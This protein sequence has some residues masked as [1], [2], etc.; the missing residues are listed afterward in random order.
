VLREHADRLVCTSVASGPLL[1]AGTLAQT[2]QGLG[3]AAETATQ[4]DA[5]LARALQLTRADGWVLVAGSF[6]LAGAVRSL[7]Q[8]WNEFNARCSR[9]SPTSS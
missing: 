4:P 9:S 7:T 6:Y 8:P 5:G 2:A 3:I 1:D